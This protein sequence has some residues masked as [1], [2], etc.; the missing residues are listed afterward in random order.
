TNTQANNNVIAAESGKMYLS[1]DKRFLV[2]ELSK[3]WR[4]EFKKDDSGAYEQQRMYFKHWTKVV[5]VSSFEFSRT[6]ED[7]F[8][9]NE[10][11]MDIRMLSQNMDSLGRVT[12]S[13]LKELRRNTGHFLSVVK[14]DNTYKEL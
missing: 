9:T 14:S 12:N 13:D 7:L 3:G 2:F 8:R 6:Q 1:N 10:E 4:Y 5:D 11:M